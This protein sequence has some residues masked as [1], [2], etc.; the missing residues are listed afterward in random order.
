MKPETSIAVAA[1]RSIDLEAARLEAL[2]QL[3]LEMQRPAV[4][5]ERQEDGLD[6]AR[7]ILAIER[8]GEHPGIYAVNLARKALGEPKRESGQE[9]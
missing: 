8:A 6:W 5:Y 9:G 7:K 4:N 3:E 2:R 1:Q